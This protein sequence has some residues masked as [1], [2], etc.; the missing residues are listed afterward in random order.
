MRNT[1]RLRIA[2][3][4]VVLI[5]VFMGGLGF[6]LSNFVRQSYEDKWR[7]DLLATDRL[8]ARQVGSLMDPAAAKGALDGLAVEYAQQVNTRVTIIRA[9]GVVLGES[10][11][12]IDQ[13]ENHFTRPEVLQ[14]LSNQDGYQIRFSTTLNIMMLYVAV[15]ISQNG[16]VVGVSRLSVPLAQLEADLY[17][18]QMTIGLAAFAAALLAIGLAILITNSAIRPLRQ[19]TRA[20]RQLGTGNFKTA[21]IPDSDDEFGQLSRALKQMAV[22][23]D[24]QIDDLQVER[25]K[26]AAVLSQMTD[27]VIITNAEG[28]VQLINPAAEKLFK[29]KASFALGRSMV[30]IVR[31]HQLVETWKKSI[32]SGEQQ[33][34]TLEV[35]A[36]NLFLQSVVIPLREMLPGST[37]ILCQDLTRLRRLEMVRR[38]FISNV[39]HELRTPLASLKALVETLQE[40]ALEDPP[41]ARRFLT[42]MDTEIDTLTQMV[43]VLLELSRIESGRVPLELKPVT[44]L[45]LL[46]PAV[47]RMRLQA[48]RAGISLRMECPPDL[49]Q[50]QADAGRMEQV[51]VNLLHNAVKFTPP[52][53]EIVVSAYPQDQMVVFTVKDTG[54]GIAPEDLPRIFERFYKADRARSSGGTGLGLSIARHMVEAH[55][56]RIWAESEVGSGST[57]YFS[58]PVV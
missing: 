27:G 1:I 56:G 46:T 6:Y 48:E 21:E 54:V 16:Q 41:A 15:P 34:T 50:V 52:N 32:E 9:D 28:L 31:H 20:A 8:V 17:R 39:S 26:L 40:G 42:R 5:V 35:K 44:P 4:Y 25:G 36:E 47:E 13:M 38:D 37:L 43:Q 3:P 57:F 18:M 53:G 2:I 30:E 33:S 11:A 14:A 45:A 24:G 7:T 58:L 19:L 51:L 22:H 23:L 49:P 55:G 12:N 29:V 10:T